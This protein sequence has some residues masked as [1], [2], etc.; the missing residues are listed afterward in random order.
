M[1]R[2]ALSIL[3]VIAIAP[4]AFAAYDV[5]ERSHEHF[6]GTSVGYEYLELKEINFDRLY[7]TKL[8]Q[9]AAEYLVH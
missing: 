7:L 8:V 6:D 1:E 4:V 2:L 9:N 3:T 5:D